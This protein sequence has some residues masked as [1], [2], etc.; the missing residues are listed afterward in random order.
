MNLSIIANAKINIGLKITGLLDNG[1]HTLHSL[2][3]EI[4]LCDHISAGLTDDGKIKLTSTGLAIPG[5]E[6]LVEKAALLL[7]KKYNVSTG[8]AIRLQKNIPIGAGLGG[9]SSDAAATVRALNS[10]WEL[11]I[12][13]NELENLASELGADVP[14]FIQ[15]GLQLA[16]G[17]GEILSP[18]VPS[19]FSEYTILLVKPDF[20]VSTAEAYAELNKYLRLPAESPKFAAS[21]APINWRLFEN[22]FERVLL[23]TYPEVRTIKSTLLEGGAVFA[24]LSGSG[25]TMFGIF[26]HR[27]LAA[28]ASVHLSAYQT[29]VT[30]PVECSN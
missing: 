9:G 12:S 3:Q 16:E 10:L 13:R 19:P 1:Y 29:I 26:D 24:G 25:S 18:I 23:S 15:G 21:L 2:F 4:D 17:T 22:D 14:F 6:N 30:H 8:A 27:E 28:Q 5:K 7:Q 11:N 20:S